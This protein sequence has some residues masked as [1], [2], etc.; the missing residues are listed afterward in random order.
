V[1]IAVREQLLA[2]RLTGAA[3]QPAIEP[4]A[5]VVRSE[6]EALEWTPIVT[7]DGGVDADD[8]LAE[9]KEEA[10]RRDQLRRRHLGGGPGE[11]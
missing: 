1:A 9:A 6:A 8:W 7:V 4:G 10:E 2:A 11:E 3:A 5:P